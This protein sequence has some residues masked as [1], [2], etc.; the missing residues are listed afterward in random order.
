MPPRPVPED[1]LV[2]D[3]PGGA[4]TA[5]VAELEKRLTAQ[6]EAL[7]KRLAGQFELDAPDNKLEYVD[8]AYYGRVIPPGLERPPRDV[9]EPRLW[10]MTDDTARALAEKRSQAAYDEYRHLGCYAFFEADRVFAE[11]ADA[12]FCTPRRIA[13]SG[14]LDQLRRAFDDKTLEI[15]LS[16]AGKARAAAAFAKATPDKPA[17]TESA[18]RRKQRE[19][20]AAARKAAATAIAADKAKAKVTKTAPLRGD[21]RV[22]ARTLR[23]VGIQNVLFLVPKPGT[24]KWRLIIDLREL[25]KWCKS[26]TMS[27]KTLKHLRHLARAGDWFVSMDLADGYYALGIREEDRDFFTVNYRGELW[28][29]ACLP[30]AYSPFPAQHSLAGRAAPTLYDDFLFLADSRE[31]ALELRVRLNT[32]LDRLGMLRNPN[33]GVWEPTQVGPHQGLIVDLQRGEFRAPEEKLIALARVARS[34]LG[35]AAS[36]K[37]RLPARQLASFA[38]KA[39]FMYLAITPARFLLRELHCVLATR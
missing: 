38:G 3:A 32:S 29:L 14:Q 7:E 31:A 12:K 37:R 17:P 18:E 23:Q 5:S 6:A 4:T 8:F 36:D 34:L 33:K 2:D 19:Q 16:A 26:F 1:A 11:L 35:R 15:S 9:D 39:Q 28:R 13:V 30:M 24:N 25:N 20:A 22:G 21:W 10:T 27:Y